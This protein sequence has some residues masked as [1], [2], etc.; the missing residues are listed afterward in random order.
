MTST[1]FLEKKEVISYA[2]LEK[3]LLWAFV[4]EVQKI[5]LWAL[6]DET[7]WV[8]PIEWIDACN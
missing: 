2:S 3:Y 8:H 5:R 6:T 7:A 1:V 4:S